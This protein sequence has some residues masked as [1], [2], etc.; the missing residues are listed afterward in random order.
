MVSV[1]L[2][3]LESKNNI[4]G[5]HIWLISVGLYIITAWKE[6]GL[7]SPF[8]GGPPDTGGPSCSVKQPL[9]PDAA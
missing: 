4:G 2:V 6:Q 1:S 9:S 7:T 3:G 8:P 5:G